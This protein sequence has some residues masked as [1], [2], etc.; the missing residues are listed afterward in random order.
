MI[1]LTLPDDSELLINAD[2]II[3]VISSEPVSIVLSGGEQITVKESAMKIHNL[4]QAASLHEG[5]KDQ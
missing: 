5:K 2:Y 3:K 4:I 1:K